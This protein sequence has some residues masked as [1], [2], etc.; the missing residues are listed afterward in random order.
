MRD[1]PFEQAPAGVQ[2]SPRFEKRDVLQAGKECRCAVLLGWLGTLGTGRGL[3]CRANCAISRSRDL[4]G[5]Q[6]RLERLDELQR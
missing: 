3:S 5:L 1:Q 6:N 4:R 2:I